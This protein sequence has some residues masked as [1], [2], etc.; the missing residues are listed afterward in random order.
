MAGHVGIVKLPLKKG[1]EGPLVN[2]SSHISRDVLFV[3]VKYKYDTYRSC[4]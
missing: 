4:C 2:K 3:L 1:K